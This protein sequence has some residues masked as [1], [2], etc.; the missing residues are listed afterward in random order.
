MDNWEA[1]VVA[2]LAETTEQ[3]ATTLSY[4]QAALERAHD[5]LA[6]LAPLRPQE[7]DDEPNDK[8]ATWTEFLAG[9][10]ELTATED[11]TRTG[12][13]S[14]RRKPNTKKEDTGR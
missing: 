7:T 4:V 13:R 11:E 12:T 3:L 14:R 1:G 10:P 9:H 8:P 2:S 5:S 6:A